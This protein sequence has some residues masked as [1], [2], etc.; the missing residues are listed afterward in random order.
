MQGNMI[1]NLYI[2]LTLACTFLGANVNVWEKY[3]P[4]DSLDQLV[5]IAFDGM[6]YG[7]F[8]GAILPILIGIGILATPAYLF[9]SLQLQIS[10]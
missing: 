8:F 10:K 6:G 5:L 4:S 2:Y 3:K 1:I 9:K 7:F